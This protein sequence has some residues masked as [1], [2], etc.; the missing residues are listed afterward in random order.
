MGEA[1]EFLAVH[2]FSLAAAGRIRTGFADPGGVRSAGRDGRLAGAGKPKGRPAAI[3]APLRS[4][5]SV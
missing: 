2:P 4:V 5:R 3:G 1:G